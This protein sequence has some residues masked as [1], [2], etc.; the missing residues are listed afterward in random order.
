MACVRRN[1]VVL[2]VVATVKP[3]R[4]RHSRQPARWRDFREG[5]GG[6]TNSAPGRARISRQTIAQGRPGLGCPVS[7]LCIACAFVARRGLMGASRRPAFPAPFLSE[8]GRDVKQ[9]SGKSCRENAAACRF[10]RDVTR[11]RVLWSGIR[12]ALT[13]L[14]CKHAAPAS[15][16]VVVPAKICI[17]RTGTA[18]DAAGLVL[19][20]CRAFG[21]CGFLLIGVTI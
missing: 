6:Q 21:G 1:R 7:P 4:R 14:P 19:R 17:M 18:R 13:G 8:R 10:D 3:W 5:E 9:S 2:A 12:P 16:A 15:A 20:S 11:R